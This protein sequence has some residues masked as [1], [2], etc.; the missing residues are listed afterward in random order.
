MDRQNWLA[1]QFEERRP[2]LRAVA[3]R[4]LGS[5]SEADDAVQET[6]LR[7]SRADSTAVANLGG[8]LTTIVARVCL[9]LLEARRVRREESLDTAPALPIVM[10]AD[11]AGP[12]GATLLD[13]EIGSALL[14]IL[15]TLPPA[16]RVALVLHDAFAVP[17]DLIAPIVGRTPAATR[18]LASRARRRVRE[19]HAPPVDHARQR[20]VVEAFLAAAQEGDFAALL[21]VLDPN[22]TLHIESAGAPIA[23]SGARAVAEG[24]RAGALV[25]GGTSAVLVDSQTGIIAWEDDGQ[26]R[27]LLRFTIV[28]EE[29]A[30]ITAYTDPAVLAYL[31]VRDP[32]D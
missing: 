13:E 7:A 27:A 17:F 6:W 32:A 23:I 20:N 12:E 28:G 14:V 3:H 30:A 24:A 16:E 31:G 26:P 5:A 25:A 18:Q 11:W 29:I 10:R 4:I 15:D 19:E 2:H 1:G 21:A 8:W 9:N 22:V